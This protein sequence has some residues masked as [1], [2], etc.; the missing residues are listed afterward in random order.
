MVHT[1]EEKKKCRVDS[2]FLAPHLLK[3]MADRGTTAP[4]A[5]RQLPELR[6][7]AN[8]GGEQTLFDLLR[9]VLHTIFFARSLGKL[10]PG[11]A[12]VRIHRR[13]RLSNPRGARAMR[14]AVSSPIPALSTSTAVPAGASPGVA[15][16][17]PRD[18][19]GSAPIPGGGGEGDDGGT[20]LLPD[21]VAGF[22]E[23]HADD[24]E[25]S[26][27]SDRATNDKAE[28]YARDLTGAWARARF[29]PQQRTL[30]V[31]FSAD[32]SPAWEEWRLPLA[33]LPES[34]ET[35][36]SAH[37]QPLASTADDLRAVLG[38][39]SELA[40]EGIAAVPGVTQEASARA[41]VTFPENVFFADTAGREVDT[42]KGG[43]FSTLTSFFTGD[44]LQ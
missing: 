18:D 24:V 6:V 38:R 44:P 27:G 29:T 10:T 5:L 19:R 43:F 37:D 31:A 41:G 9:A 30:V 12:V 32:S 16:G 21:D 15:A 13:D 42:A 3:S 34:V 8:T 17:A 22:L 40:V 39:I 26:T 25:F 23:E 14:R 20:A 33:V 36:D 28:K 1:V 2:Y 35:S 4:P 11:H 7:V